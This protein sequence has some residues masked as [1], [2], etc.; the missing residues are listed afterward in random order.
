V[1]RAV[2]TTVTGHHTGGA[3]AHYR[4]RA[5]TGLSLPACSGGASSS[6]TWIVMVP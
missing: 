5:V 3:D 1:E 4:G 6:G 2:L